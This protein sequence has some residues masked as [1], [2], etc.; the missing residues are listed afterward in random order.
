VELD[1]EGEEQ[2]E[3]WPDPQLHTTLHGCC[4]RHRSKCTE[5]PHSGENGR[6]LCLFSIQNVPATA[7][8]FCPRAVIR[9]R[10]YVLEA[11]VQWPPLRHVL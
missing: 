6:H 1:I 5:V 3:V 7:A 2:P 9:I 11:I 8:H 10:L 4:F